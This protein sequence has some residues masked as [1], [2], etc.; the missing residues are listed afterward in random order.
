MALAAMPTIASESAFDIGKRLAGLLEQAEQDT[1]GGELPAN[2]R[3]RIAD[4]VESVR[5]RLARNTE[6]DPRSLFDLDERLIELMDQAEDAVAEHGEIPPELLQQINDY[7]ESFRTK[8]DR[9]AGYWRWQ[10][11]IAEICGKE[12]ERLEARRKAAEGRLVD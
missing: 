7:I 1:D 11:S 6:R 3:D 2:I 4:L 9:I 5:R 8:I 12:A 10:E